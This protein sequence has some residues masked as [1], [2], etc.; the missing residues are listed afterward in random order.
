[1]PH[2]TERYQWDPAVCRAAGGVQFLPA[3]PF[4]PEKLHADLTHSPGTSEAE[5]TFSFF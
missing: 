1:V 5:V 4:A 2:T 3:F